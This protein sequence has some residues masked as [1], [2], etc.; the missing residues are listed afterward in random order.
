MDSRAGVDDTEKRKFMT[1]PGLE[2][3][4]VSIQTSLSRL[5]R[6]LRTYI[7]SGLNGCALPSVHGI[8]SR[9]M[10]TLLRL[11]TG[12]QQH[13]QKKHPQLANACHSMLTGGA[14]H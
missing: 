8:A 9:Q 6:T 10:Q 7:L 1:L 13:H 12:G 3:Q 14:G 11:A 5:R 4:P 2:L